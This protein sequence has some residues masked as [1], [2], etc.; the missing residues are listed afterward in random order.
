MVDSK[1]T[2]V[3]QI[4]S[5]RRQGRIS[6]EVTLQLRPNSGE[7]DSFEKNQG[8]NILRRGNRMCKGS[9]AGE[10]QGT[11]GKGRGSRVAG[12]HGFR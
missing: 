5:P 12:T 3:G 4:Y 2:R 1:H 10:S 6:E 8:M 9:V 7:G 11:L